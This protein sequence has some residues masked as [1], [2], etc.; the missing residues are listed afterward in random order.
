MNKWEGVGLSNDGIIRTSN[1]SE[2]IIEK[3]PE[4][5]ASWASQGESKEMPERVPKKG[6]NWNKV[7]SFNFQLN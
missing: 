1:C 3:Q 2:T 6:R 7:I 4:T 5:K